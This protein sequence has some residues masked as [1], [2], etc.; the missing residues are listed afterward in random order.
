MT[1]FY[2]KSNGKAKLVEQLLISF[3]QL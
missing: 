3:R 2:S 1:F